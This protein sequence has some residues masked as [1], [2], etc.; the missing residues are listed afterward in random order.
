MIVVERPSTA[1]MRKVH[2]LLGAGD[3]AQP[4]CVGRALPFSDTRWHTVRSHVPDP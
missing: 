3:F 1:L 2:E 4:P